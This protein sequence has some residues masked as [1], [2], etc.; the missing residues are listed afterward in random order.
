MIYGLSR[1]EIREKGKELLQFVELWEFRNRPLKFFSGGMQRRFEIARSLLHEPEVLFL[2]E[3]TIGLDPQTRA[4]IWDYIR[5][6][7]ER[8]VTIFLTTH[9]MDEAELLADRI[10]IMEGG[11]IIAE[12]TPEELKRLVGNDVI[13]LRLEGRA[14]CLKADFVKGCKVLPDGRI[15]LD[16]DNAAEALPKLFEIANEMNLRITEVTY[17]RPTLNDVFLHL[18][19]R[20][21]RDEE[22]NSAKGI[23]QSWRRLR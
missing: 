13:Y 23:M 18:T 10:A 7:K 2:D 19:G 1:D 22:G 3:P 15:R 11:R 17:H 12:G 16:V 4:H 9:Y 8:N 21:I 5:A 6:M 14:E 20:E